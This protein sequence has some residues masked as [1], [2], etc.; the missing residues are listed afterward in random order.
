MRHCDAYA[1]HREICIAERKHRRYWTVGEQ[2]FLNMIKEPIKA[3]L[4]VGPETGQE[5]Q[6]LYRKS[7]GG[8]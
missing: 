2:R 3:G 1:L 4:D 6:R 7:Q 5:L 8:Y